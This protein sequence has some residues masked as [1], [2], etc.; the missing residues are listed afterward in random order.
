MRLIGGDARNLGLHIFLRQAH[1]LRLQISLFQPG[2]G[3]CQIRGVLQTVGRKTG[4]AVGIIFE[5]HQSPN[6]VLQLPGG[7]MYQ[8][9]VNVISNR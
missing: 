6:L 3:F 5:K 1:Q 8:L 9:V 7:C 4:I 2:Q